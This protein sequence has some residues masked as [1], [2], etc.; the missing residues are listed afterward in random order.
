MWPFLIV[1]SRVSYS[2]LTVSLPVAGMAATG[3]ESANN[4][5]AAAKPTAPRVG[6]LN[7]LVSLIAESPRSL[8]PS[9]RRYD[10]SPANIAPKSYDLVDMDQPGVPIP[11]SF[12]RM[13]E[14]RWTHRDAT[15]V[16]LEI[17]PRELGWLRPPTG[18]EGHNAA[19]QGPV[20]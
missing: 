18:S 4:P 10:Q 12:K 13:A 19:G 11:A 16:G 3:E 15:M 8:L 17:P 5:S 1:L 2:P 14:L 7:F 6:I 20:E 9:D